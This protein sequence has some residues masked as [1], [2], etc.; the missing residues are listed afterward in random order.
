MRK[1]KVARLSIYSNS[2]LVALKFGVGLMMGSVSIISEAIHSLI[3]LFAAVIANV[4]V[5]ESSKP[6]DLKHPYGHDKYENV[7]AVA[8][9]LLIFL[10]AGLIVYESGKRLFESVEV[11]MLEVGIAVMALSAVINLVVSDKLYKVG[12]E[13]ESMA[14]IGDGLHLRTDV[15]TSIGVVVGLVLIRLTGWHIIDPLIGIA[16]A[17]MIVKAAFDLTLEASQGLV[18][19]SVSEEERRTI[20]EVLIGY[21]KQS[22]TYSCLRA[23]KSGAKR[24][25]DLR[26]EM[27]GSMNLSHVHQVCDSIE[28]ELEQKLPGCDVIIHCEPAVDGECGGFET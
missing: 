7:A 23:R 14:L 18:D 19:A 5:R 13:E 21:E 9:A 3:D 22:V 16:V 12:R 6:P 17:I 11:E 2:F 15:L 24:F 26:L 28:Q 10:A 25:I 4:S 1:Q 27:D 20:E 8:E